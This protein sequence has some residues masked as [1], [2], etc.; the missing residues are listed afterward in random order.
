MNKKEEFRNFIKNRPE[1]ISYVENNDMTWQKFYE[2]YDLY[3]EDA[4]IWDK[5]KDRSTINIS[6][7]LNK[8]TNMVKNVDM[9]SLKNHINTAQK[10]LDLVQ[11]FTTKKIN[12]VPTTNLSKGPL[13]PRPL[14]K[15]FED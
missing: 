11:D 4:S 5:Y 2:I 7:G 3:G 8:I 9:S 10:A 15:F 14:N 12:E 13:S 1:L 6:D